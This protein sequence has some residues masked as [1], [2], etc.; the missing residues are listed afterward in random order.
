MVIMEVSKNNTIFDKNLMP[1][2]F[3]WINTET[4]NSY[5]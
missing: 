5:M 2:I 4:S 3:D 1:A